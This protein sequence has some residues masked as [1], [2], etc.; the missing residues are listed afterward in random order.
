MS[1]KIISHT[2]R[3]VTGLR[4]SD[5]HQSFLLSFFLRTQV[6][7]PVEAYD[8]NLPLIKTTLSA[9]IVDKDRIALGTEEGLFIVELRHDG[10]FVCSI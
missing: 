6:F 3:K 2:N 7:R 1:Y 5:F 4:K 10:E 8:C 9:A